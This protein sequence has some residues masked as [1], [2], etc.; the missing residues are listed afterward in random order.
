MQRA[1]AFLL[2]LVGGAAFLFLVKLMHDMTAHMAR[3]TDQVAAISADLGRVHAQMETLTGHVAAMEA[4]VRHMG[5]MAEDMRAMGE[6][7]GSMAGVVH[8]G[9]EQIERLNPMQMLEQMTRPRR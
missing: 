7:I 4:S 8:K 3:M 9:G 5:P 6:N 2:A 1:V